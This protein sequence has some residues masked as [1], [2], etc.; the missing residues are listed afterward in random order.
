MSEHSRPRLI[1]WCSVKHNTTFP[2]LNPYTGRFRLRY[3]PEVRETQC[4]Y[5][6]LLK[7]T[8][9]LIVNVYQCANYVIATFL[10]DTIVLLGNL[11]FPGISLPAMNYAEVGV[12]LHYGVL[13]VLIKQH[14]ASSVFCSGLA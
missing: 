1:I 3:H 13:S 8:L 12:E 7:T 5:F 2:F 4:K 11:Y 14:G 6:T 9:T 10:S